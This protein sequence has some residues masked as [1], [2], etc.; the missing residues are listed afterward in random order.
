MD[1]LDAFFGSQCARITQTLDRIVERH[2]AR[3]ARAEV[4]H[5]RAMLQ[6]MAYDLVGGSVTTFTMGPRRQPLDGMEQQ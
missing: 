3:N 4:R 2:D 6:E 1:D 5:R